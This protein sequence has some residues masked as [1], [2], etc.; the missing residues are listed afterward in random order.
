MGDP[1]NLDDR[2]AI[3]EYNPAFGGDTWGGPVNPLSAFRFFGSALHPITVHQPDSWKDCAAP[4][5]LEHSSLVRPAVVGLLS[6]PVVDSGMRVVGHIGWFLGTAIYVPHGSNLGFGSSSADINRALSA[7]ET[8]YAGTDVPRRG[9]IAVDGYFRD[10]TIVVGPGDTFR[11]LSTNEQ[12]YRLLTNPTGQ[13]LLVLAT[14]LVGLEDARDKLLMMLGLVQIAASIGRWG[15]SR[16]TS[17]AISKFTTRDIALSLEAELDLAFGENAILQRGGQGGFPVLAKLPKLSA[18][19]RAAAS[20]LLGQEFRP[21]LKA[22][23]NACRNPQADKE[24]A[25]V[26]RLLKTGS[27]A[28]REAAYKLSEKVYENWRNRFWTRVRGN[29]SLKKIFTDA[30][31]KFDGKSGAPYFE[32]DGAKTKNLTVTLD[33]FI[34]RRVDNPARAVDALNVRP[35]IS[36]ENSATL[37]AIRRDNFLKGWKSPID[38]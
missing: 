1:Q 15:I 22:A 10:P 36:F 32:I 8:I 30:G 34:E 21:E 23:W 9:E 17:L 4:W 12:R 19:A 16:I 24:L 31:A 2:R 14:D 26:A 20:K 6:T 25:E 38:P 5:E 7:G 27:A 33:H 18:D 37:E 13:V 35:T 3:N 11:E 28:D 29:S